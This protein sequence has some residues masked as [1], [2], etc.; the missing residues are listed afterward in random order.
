M[1]TGSD[2]FLCTVV[3]SNKLW[4]P[5]VTQISVSIIQCKTQSFSN[6]LRPLFARGALRLWQS[7]LGPRTALSVQRHLSA[8]HH[9]SAV[10]D[11]FN[12]NLSQQT[13]TELCCLGRKEGPE[14]VFNG[15]LRHGV[16]G[17]SK[18]QAKHLQTLQDFW[19][20]W[21]SHDIECK[22]WETK[23]KAWRRAH[24]LWLADNE[25]WEG[26][27]DSRW[28]EAV[29]AA[30][31]LQRENFDPDS[32][33]EPQEPQKPNLKVYGCRIQACSANEGQ[34]FVD[35]LSHCLRCKPSTI[36]FRALTQAAVDN[37]EADLE[38]TYLQN[39]DG[40][41]KQ[42]VVLYNFEVALASHA[43]IARKLLSMLFARQLPVVL[44]SASPTG[45]TCK[46]SAEEELESL[47]RSHNILFHDLYP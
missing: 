20:A 23:H 17:P 1:D 13:W 39:V 5:F 16:F 31:D 45:K 36:C 33:L 7:V 12:A 2:A 43:L 46:F 37:L 8:T 4:T 9:E 24:A 27:A 28:E 18:T 21:N 47:M 34:I 15:M 29:N 40:Y 22:A 32:L 42:L 3:L 41:R 38:S 14:A 19:K 25:D 26:T 44:L 10:P 35:I 6:M 30:H 11:S